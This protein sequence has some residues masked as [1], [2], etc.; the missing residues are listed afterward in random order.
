MNKFLTK[1]SPKFQYKNRGSLA[2]MGFG[3]GVGDLTNTDFPSPDATMS[4]LV[5][6][7]TWRTT[8]LTKQL[9]W[10]NMMLIPMYWFKAL[11]F[12]RDISRF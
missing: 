10:S 5:A 2:G 4:G 8:Y 6:F 1:S 12:G 11:V 9:S 3:G 7:L